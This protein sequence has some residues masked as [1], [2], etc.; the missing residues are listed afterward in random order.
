MTS[1][2]AAIKEDRSL[3]DD[4]AGRRRRGIWATLAL[5]ALA[6]G[7]AIW[8]VMDFD[9][10]ID[11]EYPTVA[12]PVFS[13]YPPAA[14]RLAEP[15]DT[16]DRIELYLTALAAVLAGTGF[17]RHRAGG[18]W[19]AA[20]LLALAGV[21]HAATPGPTFDGWHG[22]GF[23]VALDPM[24]PPGLRLGMAGITAAL[25]AAI[26]ANVWSRRQNLGAIWTIAGERGLH[27]PAILGAILILLRQVE[28]PL[29]GPVG[30][31][32]RCSMNAGIALGCWCLIQA[33]AP[34]PRLALRKRLLGASAATAAWLAL[35][36]G[37]IALTWYHRPL[38]RL[39]VVEP[40][41]ILM[42]A[43]PTPRGLAVAQARHHFKTIIN[44]F[45]EDTPLRSPLFPAE[46]EF[47]RTHGIRYV[48]SPSNP[49]D[50]ASNAFL[51]ETLRLAQDP[52]AWPILVHCHGCMDRTPAWMG[53][54]R[55]LVQGRPL[56]DSMQEIERHRGY[57][58]K[59]SVVLLYNRVLPPRAGDR[60][61]TDPAAQLLRECAAGV[62]DRPVPQLSARPANPDAKKGV[63]SKD[64]TQRR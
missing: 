18:L 15:G 21:W 38:A 51:D 19:P 5:L 6:I 14:Y 28:P 41:R 62:V 59:A 60:Y 43:M 27:L 17:M 52:S 11:P 54:Y 29:P 22:L 56:M 32:P 61:W 9:E 42:S 8:H 37:G 34:W 39:R 64:A 4:K 25:L 63:L 44:L 1:K 57:R 53:I 12:T 50:E 33:Q 45:P 24:A 48:R 55:F 20:L 31:W 35:T 16:L 3:T 49:S 36:A 40:G 58:P 46:V 13:P 2:T 47:A 10:D 30:Y 26:A 23:R 7:P